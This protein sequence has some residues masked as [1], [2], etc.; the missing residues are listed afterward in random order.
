MQTTYTIADVQAVRLGDMDAFRVVFR[1]DDGLLHGL[2]FPADTLAWRSAELGIDP[3]DTETLLDIVLHEP[4]VTSDP[5]VG[6]GSQ[7][8][9]R[10]PHLARIAEAKRRVTITTRPDGPA[11]P[12]DVIRR[13]VVHPDRVRDIQHRLRGIRPTEP[14]IDDSATR[15]HND[16]HWTA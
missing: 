4:F 16:P 15:R 9:A 10:E 12:L 1:R 2:L 8:P 5:P 14:P 7:A 11:D 13:H 6:E 3:A